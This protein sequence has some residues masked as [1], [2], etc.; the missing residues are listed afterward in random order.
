MWTRIGDVLPSVLKSLLSG[1]ADGCW[2]CDSASVFKGVTLATAPDDVQPILSLVPGVVMGFDS[3]LHSARRA[4]TRFL[5]SARRERACDGHLCLPLLRRFAIPRPACVATLADPCLSS[6]FLVCCA[7]GQTPS[8]Q[9]VVTTAIDPELTRRL[10]ARTVRAPLL[11]RYGVACL[12]PLPWAWH[13][14]RFTQ[15]RRCR[16][17]ARNPASR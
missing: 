6:C 7:T 16:L 15:Q 5:Q 17:S 1:V 9:P 8:A 3:S 10:V 2:F 14:S 11:A 4:H 12:W 13:V